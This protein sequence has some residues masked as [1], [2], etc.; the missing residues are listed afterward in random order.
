MATPPSPD[1]EPPK[2]RRKFYAGPT[3]RVE[4]PIPPA[5]VPAPP[6][7]SAKPPTGPAL[8]HPPLPPHPEHSRSPFYP[9][10]LSG[11][12]PYWPPVPYPPQGYSLYPPG[13][14]PRT[15]A[16]PTSGAPA[17]AAPST[18]ASRPDPGPRAATAAAGTSGQNAQDAPK[19]RPP[20][21]LGAPGALPEP[22]A[23]S[24]A[25]AAQPSDEA[26]R[27]GSTPSASARKR[28]DYILVTHDDETELFRLCLKHKA[29]Y[30]GRGKGKG[31]GAFYRTVTADFSALSGKV[32]T[33]STVQRHVQTE[34]N[35]YLNRLKEGAEGEDE[36]ETTKWSE[37]RKAWAEVETRFRAEL[38]GDRDMQEL[39]DKGLVRGRSEGEA[40]A[41]E[42]EGRVQGEERRDEG[43]SSTDTGNASE[44]HL[45]AHKLSNSM[46]GAP[47]DLRVQG[48]S[49]YGNRDTLADA[50]N[51]FVAVQEQLLAFKER[52]ADREKQRSEGQ[53]E[54]QRAE[55]ALHRREAYNKEKV[56]NLAGELA[57]I[58]SEFHERL[59]TFEQKLDSSMATIVD[60]LN[61]QGEEESE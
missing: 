48:E 56:D 41:G 8:A 28:A 21:M 52:K 1:T 24:G 32:A 4:K 42:Y 60:L 31:T 7:T 37:A 34:T 6:L 53:M 39:L 45:V 38:L 50:M 15:S 40:E 29:I 2:K 47:R 10:N 54:L 35:K 43:A 23:L 44:D 13:P 61:R 5:T 55:L 36:E 3:F 26:G 12:H 19:T 30:F 16:P 25:T 17:P 46:S 59:S 58:K 14:G 22:S 11:A 9:P 20:Q 27:Q 18:P 49:S 33:A 57:S 51:D